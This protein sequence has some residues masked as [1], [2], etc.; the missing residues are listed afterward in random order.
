MLALASKG[1]VEEGQSVATDLPLIIIWLSILASPPLQLMLTALGLFDKLSLGG[2][3]QQRVVA[4]GP[5]QDLAKLLKD[6]K[7]ENAARG[8]VVLVVIGQVV[9]LKVGQGICKGHGNG[10]GEG[11]RVTKAAHG[12]DKV[13]FTS[14]EIENATHKLGGR[15]GHKG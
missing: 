1:V 11:V 7:V 4:P 13:G 6:K 8:N 3:C 9:P 14:V 2:F 15:E 5:T 10:D 12:R